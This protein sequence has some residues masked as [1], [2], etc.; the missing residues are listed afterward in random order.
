[1]NSH[2]QSYSYLPFGKN[3]NSMRPKRL[4]L[5]NYNKVTLIGHSN[6]GDMSILFAHKYP[7]L[8]NKVISLDNRRMLF[9]LTK[10]PQIY[11]L[12]SSDQPADE[13]VLPTLE[14]QNKYKITI[15][16]LLNTIHNDMDDNANAKQRKEIGNYLL[17]FLKN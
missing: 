15:V 9:P 6:G 12:R 3:T 17:E 7:T 5:L 14:N 2:Q 1:L 4:Y 8:I 10:Q 16:K 11:S 13:G